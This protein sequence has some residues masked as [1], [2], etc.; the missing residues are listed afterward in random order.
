[1]QRGDKQ[2]QFIL[3]STVPTLLQSAAG[4]ITK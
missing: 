4:R 3:K 2:R 1:M